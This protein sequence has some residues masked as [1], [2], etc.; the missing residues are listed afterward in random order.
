MAQDAAKDPVE[1]H[2]LTGV[3]RSKLRNPD[4]ATA[5][6]NGALDDW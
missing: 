5:Y 4:R 1:I 2:A 3:R 6:L